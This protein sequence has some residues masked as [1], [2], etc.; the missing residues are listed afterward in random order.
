M[1]KPKLVK[2][3]MDNIIDELVKKSDHKILAKW[4]TD[5]AVRV[6]HHFEKNYPDDMRP[7]EAIEAG[8]A[9]IRE[10]IKMI[11][12]R[13]FAVTSHAASRSAEK[14]PESQAAAR[15]EVMLLEQLI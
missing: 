7:R 4:A 2:T 5:C 6:L 1:G 10:D 15:S 3:K 13:K 12:A 11:D 8:R 9:W 14:N